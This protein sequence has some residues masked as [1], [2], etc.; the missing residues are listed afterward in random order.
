[1]R[2][3]GSARR[4]QVLAASRWATHVASARVLCTLRRLL[5]DGGVTG[6]GSGESGGRLEDGPGSGISG[7]GMTPNR[8][9]LGTNHGLARS[10]RAGSLTGACGGPGLAGAGGIRGLCC[11]AG[12]A[13]GAGE[14]VVDVSTT[15]V[16]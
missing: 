6:A 3:P 13:A 1:M 5:T 14:L 8:V 7:I 9:R 2:M 11:G 12:S 15:A 10:I 16:V 4:A